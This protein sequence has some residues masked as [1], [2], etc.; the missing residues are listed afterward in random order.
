MA[1]ASNYVI[2]YKKTIIVKAGTRMS[3]DDILVMVPTAQIVEVRNASTRIGVNGGDAVSYRLGYIGVVANG[4]T[5]MF[6]EDTEVAIGV[7]VNLLP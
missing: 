4:D 1:A 3:S 7:M 6:L 2:Q 5:W